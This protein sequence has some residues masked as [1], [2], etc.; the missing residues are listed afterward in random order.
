MLFTLG[1]LLKSDVL[2][3]LFVWLALA[4]SC[5]WVY[6]Y[7]EEI[8]GSGLL[9]VLLTVTHTS[10]LLLAS[11]TYVETLVMLWTTAGVISFLKWTAAPAG[12]GAV[13][14]L[15]SGVF[16]G[17][18]FGTK[19]YAGMTIGLLFFIGLYHIYTLGTFS[20]RKA[21]MLE[22][23]AFGGIC[24]A[25]YLPW[26][27]KNLIGAGNPVFPFFYKIINQGQSGPLIESAAG[28]FY[29][30]REY[31][32]GAG[33]WAELMQFPATALTN[34][35]KFGGGMDMLGG[36]GW[37]M[38]F[39]AVPLMALAAVKNR[40]L[41]L[42]AIYLAAHW[43]V[44]FATG[45][46]LRFFTVAVP[47]ASVLAAFG[48]MYCVR[49]FGKTA[50]VLLIAGLALFTLEQ[51]VLVVQVQNLFETPR[52]MSGV[53]SR[54]QYLSRK[55]DY[56]PCA[57]AASALGPG[58]KVLYAGEHRTYYTGAYAIPSSIFRKNDFVTWSE[59]GSPA[60][61]ARQMK[62]A[63]VTAVITVPREE[64][65]LASYFTMQFT[66]QGRR[67]WNDYLAGLG[68]DYSGPACTLYLTGE[69][70]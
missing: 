20:K 44:W 54:E 24:A 39:V 4:V 19:Y 40:A 65:R 66:P 49:E 7:S 59:S 42:P 17:T 55:L 70:K 69:T 15:L 58:A 13:W 12:T 1:L 22:L 68:A 51:L 46:A 67:T 64:R 35:L 2:A 37:E 52:V 9:S 56:Y 50:R 33:L 23:A 32:Q 14:V 57:R 61:V 48:F 30:I 11:T 47:L 3:Q 43:F 27:V 41:R 36:L 53:E 21:R 28:Y 18:G 5:V 6:S 34:P 10:V 29:T 25:M 45:R 60:E 26:A 16:C 8:T 38:F 63:G 31:T 62:A